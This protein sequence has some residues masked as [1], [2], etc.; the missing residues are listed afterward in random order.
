LQAFRVGDLPVTGTAIPA[1][2]D[3]AAGT[4]PSG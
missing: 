3:A 2:T 1:A 4:T